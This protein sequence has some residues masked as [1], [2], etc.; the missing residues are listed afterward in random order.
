MTE[1]Q[2]IR[3]TRGV[4]GEE[5][6]NTARANPSNSIS[7]TDRPALGDHDDAVIARHQQLT[8]N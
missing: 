2:I 1:L 8:M 7:R 4:I 5:T 3:Q 6:E